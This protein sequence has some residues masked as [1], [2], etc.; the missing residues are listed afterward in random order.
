MRALN[1][2]A[3]LG[4]AMG[5]TL[6]T[7]DGAER[8]TDD[9]AERLTPTDGSAANGLIEGPVARLEERR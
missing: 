9:G 3:V 6:L 7:D 2:G 1:A 8:L 4:V 5:R